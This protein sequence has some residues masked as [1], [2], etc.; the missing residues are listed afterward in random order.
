MTIV[1]VFETGRRAVH[2]LIL[3]LALATR[4][5]RFTV[6]SVNYDT[7][8]VFTSCSVSRIVRRDAWSKTEIGHP[9]WVQRFCPVCWFTQSSQTRDSKC[10]TLFLLSNLENSVRLTWLPIICQELMRILKLIRFRVNPK[11]L[12]VV[13]LYT[14]KGLLGNLRWFWIIH[15]CIVKETSDRLV[16]GVGAGVTHAPRFLFSQS[17]I[18]KFTFSGTAT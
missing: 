13:R 4:F 8:F 2:G 11:C 15:Y 1:L 7:S 3:C 6:W 12:V 17:L 10:L 14:Y 18:S 5:A 9:W 16:W